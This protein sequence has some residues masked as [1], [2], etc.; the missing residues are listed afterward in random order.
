MVG[1]PAWA[2]DSRRSTFFALGMIRIE[3]AIPDRAAATEKMQA[4]LPWHEVC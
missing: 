4:Q 3:E 2:S 1:T